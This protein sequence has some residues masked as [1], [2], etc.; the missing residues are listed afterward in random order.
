M[1]QFS[2]FRNLDCYIITFLLCFININYCFTNL[3][4]IPSPIQRKNNSLFIFNYFIFKRK[5]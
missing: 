2:I 5:K 4:I 3:I 1:S